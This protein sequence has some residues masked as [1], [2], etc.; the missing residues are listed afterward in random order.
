MPT[1]P[2]TFT[3]FTNASTRFFNDHYRQLTNYYKMGWFSVTGL[4]NPVPYYPAFLLAT[5]TSTHF[6]AELLGGHRSYRPIK[7]KT[8]HAQD[9]TSYFGSF[10]RPA[11]ATNAAIHLGGGT[12]GNLCFMSDGDKDRLEERFPGVLD[13]FPTRINFV[14]PSGSPLVDIMQSPNCSRIENC[15]LV[16][17]F[18]GAIRIRHVWNAVIVPTTT[19]EY[20]YVTY[21]RQQH[22]LQHGQGVPGWKVVEYGTAE[23]LLRAAQFANAFLIT[24]LRETTLGHYLDLHRDILLAALDAKDLLTE[25]FLPWQVPSPD[26]DE[27][28]INPDLFVQRADGFW[29]IYDLK[30]PLLDKKQLTRSSRRRRRFID[31]IEDGI[32]QLA[33]YQEF[34]TIP[35]NLAYAHETYGVS[36]DEPR[37]GLIAGNYENY[38]SEPVRDALRRFPNIE[39]LDY[40]SISRL[41]IARAAGPSGME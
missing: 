10:L 25:P 34:L 37:F 16:N 18:E 2:M 21:L 28:A 11:T 31:S 3:N 19:S 15:L 26:P 39:L 36:F 20:D 41:Y 6:I 40:D 22:M 8:H 30:L 24:G 29:D 4:T 32:A 33:H 38:D 17:T 35:A 23:V 12:I 1:S 9:A 5:E 27:E 13:Q 14:R 7:A